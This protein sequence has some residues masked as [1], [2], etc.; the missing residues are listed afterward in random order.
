M[1]NIE[2]LGKVS[3]LL[4]LLAA[5]VANLIN[6][7]EISRAV[8]IPTATLH[9]YYALLETLFLVYR[10]S[11]FSDN[12]SKRLV[13]SSKLY[14]YDTGLLC[15]LLGLNEENIKQNLYLFGHVFENFVIQELLKMATWAERRV[16]FYYYRDYSQTEVDLIIELDNFDLIAIEI[17]AK[18]DI[19][20][21]DLDGIEAM[22]AHP[23]F[24]KGIIFYLGEEVLLL[25][26]GVYAL[27]VSILFPK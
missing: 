23:R 3:V 2:Q 24:K 26:Q 22:K 10:L 13:K 16:H 9:R 19:S 21:K 8:G 18:M 6:M 4:K 7:E 20:T 5:R 25:S 11:P 15:Y 17:K 1:A 12:L 14:F 27:P